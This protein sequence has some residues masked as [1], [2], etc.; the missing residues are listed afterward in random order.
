MLESEVSDW[1]LYKS[2][3]VVKLNNKPTTQNTLQ[4]LHIHVHSMYT[5]TIP[6]VYQRYSSLLQQ[7]QRIR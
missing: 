3:E 5:K 4:L 6:M 1:P 7:T 2:D